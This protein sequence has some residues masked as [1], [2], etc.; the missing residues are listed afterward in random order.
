MQWWLTV[1]FLI[2]SSW[3][4]GD[5]L[6]GW[7]SRAYD[8]AAECE[9]RL[10]FA[11][12]QTASFP[13]TYRARWICSEGQ[14]AKT[15]PAALLNVQW[16]NSPWPV[17][18]QWYGHQGEPELDIFT[19]QELAAIGPDGVGL[20]YEG[21]LKPML[22][23]ELRRLLL[24]SPGRYKRIVLELDSNGGDLRVVRDLV[25]VLRQ[26]RDQ[27]EL[28]TRVMEGGV[29]ASG[30]IPV[31]MQGE[32]RKASGASV[33]IFHGARTE[34]TNV[35]SRRAT[36]DYLDMLSS[37]GLT[38]DF[39]AELEYEDRIFRPGA[40]ILSGYEAFQVRNAGIITELLPSWRE[41]KPVLP[42]LIRSQ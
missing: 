17:K 28:T 24:A 12:A 40:L 42:S 19:V 7:H 20:R 27:M 14:P 9:A 13:L 33:W 10:R 26:V 22:A 23:Q 31:F 5:R 3:M 34:V 36:N 11:E 16:E 4:S 15:P 32:R 39:R 8:T 37:S 35:P 2:G 21:P 18:V 1:F 30:C 38:P 41:E 25:E 29:C 6:D